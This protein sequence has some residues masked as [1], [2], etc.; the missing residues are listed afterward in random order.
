MSHLMA[1][2]IVN[3]AMDCAI[4]GHDGP[5]IVHSTF[6]KFLRSTEMLS[7]YVQ[8]PLFLVYMV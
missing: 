7:M 8:H 2:Q 4:N 1:G 6:Q 3:I 5:F